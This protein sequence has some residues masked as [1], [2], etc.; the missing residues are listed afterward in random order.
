MRHKPVFDRNDP[1][2]RTMHSASIICH[3]L[4]SETAGFYIF[5]HGDDQTVIFFYNIQKLRIQWFHK[6]HIYQCRFISLFTEI[7]C[8]L[9][10]RPY[11]ISHCQN[12]NFFS[13]FQ[14]FR[15]SHLDRC[16]VLFQPGIG[17]ASRI[18][19][20]HRTVLPDGKFHHIGKFPFIFRCHDGH[21]RHHG[22][23][24]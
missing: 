12:G 11:H 10:G 22:Q 17:F 5:F 8:H 18:S 1:H 24:T 20:R 4:F 6:P 23:V 9:Y 7:F 19:D 16:P 15:F 21:I 3:H 2:C 14:N 13:F